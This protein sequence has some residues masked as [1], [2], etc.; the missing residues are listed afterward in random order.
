MASE[1]AVEGAHFWISAIPRGDGTPIEREGWVR[2]NFI[3]IGGKL[4][5]EARAVGAG[6][7]MTIK[8][9]VPWAKEWGAV[10]SFGILGLGRKSKIGKFEKSGEVGRSESDLET[11]LAEAEGEFN[12]ISEAGL[13]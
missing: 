2:Q 1:I 6:A 11:A 5:A 12:R 13:C 3:W 7:F 4:G 10:P 9:E 8:G